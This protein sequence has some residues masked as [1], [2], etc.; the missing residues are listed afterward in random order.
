[1]Q[2][3]IKRSDSYYEVELHGFRDDGVYAPWRIRVQLDDY[4]MP[5]FGIIHD[6]PA[7]GSVGG[8]GG[9]VEPRECLAIIGLL[10]AAAAHGV[11]DEMAASTTRIRSL[12]RNVPLVQRIRDRVWEHLHIW[13][14]QAAGRAANERLDRAEDALHGWWNVAWRLGA[15]GTMDTAEAQRMILEHVARLAK[16]FGLVPHPGRDTVTLADIVRA[17]ETDAREQVDAASAK[18]DGMW[19]RMHPGREA[20][21]GVQRYKASVMM[22]EAPRDLAPPRPRQPTIAFPSLGLPP[23]AIDAF[24]VG[25]ASWCSLVPSQNNSA[26]VGQAERASSR[27][28]WQACELI[29]KLTKRYAAPWQKR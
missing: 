2:M 13:D 16:V 17:A 20:A 12:V 14:I 8:Y 28:T 27:P 19:L 4:L 10:A 5:W 18:L 21:L 24:P 23:A 15:R 1:M 6:D 22:D 26:R 11:L 25:Q 29:R 7:T 9:E 3:K